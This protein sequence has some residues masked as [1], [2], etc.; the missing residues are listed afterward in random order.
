MITSPSAVRPIV[1][2]D[3][4]QEQAFRTW[5]REVTEAVNFLTPATGTGSPEGVLIAPLNK[6]YIDTTGGA[7]ALE[8]RKILADIAGDTT[9]GWQA[10]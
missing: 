7:G 3:G 4:E 5:T 10:V 1:N 6:L 8:Y 9:K 2:P